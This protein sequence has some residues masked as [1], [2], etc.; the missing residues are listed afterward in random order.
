[1]SYQSALDM[2]NK[3]KAGTI[4]KLLESS[5]SQ[6]MTWHN[7]AYVAASASLGLLLGITKLWLGTQHKTWIGLAVFEAGIVAFTILAY[8]YLTAAEHN[9][10]GNEEVKVKCEYALRL[11]DEGAYLEKIRFFWA[12]KG[13]DKG[14]PSRDI[15]ILKYANAIVGLIV[16]AACLFSYCNA[17]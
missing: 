1:M 4:V 2:N 7:Q 17:V 6:I 12:P 10:N 9:Y 13:E 14:M 8:L 15:P 3:D 5:T 16:A 11:K